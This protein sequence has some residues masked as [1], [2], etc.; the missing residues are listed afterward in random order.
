MSA[1]YTEQVIHAICTMSIPNLLQTITNAMKGLTQGDNKD[2]ACTSCAGI[3]ETIKD[4]REALDNHFLDASEKLRQYADLIDTYYT[5]CPPFANNNGEEF[6]YDKEYFKDLIQ[7]IGH[8]LVI[9]N[10]SLLDKWVLKHPQTLSEEAAQ[11]VRENIATFEDA[12]KRENW[13]DFKSR[14]KWPEQASYYCEYLVQQ[15]KVTA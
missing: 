8:S 13:Q 9:G 10:Y 2:S 1:K 3:Q 7:L 14:F 4:A 11:I 6:D 12:L 15:S 5:Q